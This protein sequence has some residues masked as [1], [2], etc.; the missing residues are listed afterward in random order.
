MADQILQNFNSLIETPYISITFGGQTFG[1]TNTINPV[2]MTRDIDYITNLTINKQASGQ[3]NTYTIT[4]IYVIRPGDDPNKI[5]KIISSDS[6]RKIKISYGDL[7]QPRFSYKEEEA[8]ITNIKPAID[9][10]RSKIVYTITATSSVVLNYA[11]KR[12]YPSVVDKPSEQ[13]YKL[14][15]LDRTNGLLELFPGMADRAKVELNRLIAK[16]DK[17]VRIEAQ[18]N[19]SPLERLKY[20]V[21][22]MQ[23]ND[24]SFY[25]LIIHDYSDY[26]KTIEGQWFEVINSSLRPSTY[27]LDLDVGYPSNTRV[28]DFQ[29]NN[30]TSFALITSYSGLIDKSRTIN[31]N[32][33]GNF[34][35]SSDPSFMVRN[36]Q[37][38]AVLESWWKTMSSF[39]VEATVKTRGLIVPAILAQTVNVNVLF[40]GRKYTYSGKYMVVGQTDVISSAGYRTTLK[41]LRIG[42][43]DDN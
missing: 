32:D 35:T 21:A 40:F 17:S 18:Q 42:A 39:P 14:L 43:N 31:I 26:D 22:Q 2:T 3:V 41:L 38:D 33:N 16:N 25:G 34:K 19:V 20:L 12:N 4:L 9:V 5:D 10:T 27:Q 24:N 28:F 29:V 8:I 37:T 36:G 7:S 11:I 23:S 1:L 15:Y 13:I 6:S 30:N